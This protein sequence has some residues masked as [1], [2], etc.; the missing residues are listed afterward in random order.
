MKAPLWLESLRQHRFPALAAASLLGLILLGLRTYLAYRGTYLFYVWNLFLAWLPLI[1]AVQA[2]HAS[3]AERPV[4]AIVAGLL[5]LLFLPNAPYLITDIVHWSPRLPIPLWF[6]LLLCVHFAWLGLALGFTS[7][8]L[9]EAEVIRRRG[10]VWG[11]CFA[12]VCLSLTSFGIYLGRF[13]RWN[14]WD[15]VR[16]PGSLFGDISVRV[17]DPFNHRGTWAFTIVCGLFLFSAY[18]VLAAMT[19]AR[20]EPARTHPATGPKA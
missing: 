5:W 7:L 8:Q 19:Q 9:L 18:W 14:S 16:A 11:R 2:A 1:F 10:V 12:L 4:R 6:D 13:R 17:L 20:N 3:R 15:I